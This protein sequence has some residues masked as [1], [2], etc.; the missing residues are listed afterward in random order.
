[1]I[2]RSLVLPARL[3]RAIAQFH[4]KTAPR[5][6]KQS[7]RGRLAGGARIQAKARNSRPALLQ[8]RAAHVLRAQP[9]QHCGQNWARN[10]KPGLPAAG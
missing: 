3:T 9:I 2:C 4:K 8:G 10:L 1:M 7:A 6:F 5:S